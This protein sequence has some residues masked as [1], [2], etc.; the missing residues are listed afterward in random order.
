VGRRSRSKKRNKLLTVSN[1]HS[2]SKRKNK[3]VHETNS[4]LSADKSAGMIVVSGSLSLRHVSITYW[5]L[6]AC[7]RVRACMWVPSC[8]GVCMRISACSLANPA[9]NAYAPYCDV[10]CGP[11]SPLYFST[12]C[13]FRKKENVIKQKMCFL[14]FSTTF[15]WN[16][17]N[18]KKN[19]ARYRQKCRNVFM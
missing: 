10:I 12:R 3:K 6:C 9:R 17:S 13:D 2:E 19:L 18:S 15:V 14:F 16:I 11:W 7:L 1:K 8:V 4:L 5:S